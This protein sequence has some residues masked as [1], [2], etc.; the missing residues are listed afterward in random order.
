ME[1]IGNSTPRYN[2][3]FDF[4]ASW[5]GFDI[6]AFFQGIIKQDFYPGTNMD[7]FWGPYSR[8][9]YSFIPKDFAND[10]WSEDNKDAYFPQLRAYVALDGNCQ[11]SVKNDRYLQN[12]GYLRFKN[13]VFGYTL[14]DALLNKLSIQKLRIYVSGENLLC[15]SPF[16][17]SD[18]IDP[19]QAASV[20]TGRTYPLSRTFSV[21]L[22]VTF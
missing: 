22:S 12:I 11:L 3:S 18:Y 2:Y 8:P 19:E 4:N 1:I 7:R 5:N 10:V 13:L 15:W 17:R 16:R 21:G 9:Y 6:N 20:D 14:P